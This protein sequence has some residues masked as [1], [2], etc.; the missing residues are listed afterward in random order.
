MDSGKWANPVRVGNVAM[1][2]HC[3]LVAVEH[4]YISAMIDYTDHVGLAAIRGL[5]EL[6][7][8]LLNAMNDEQRQHYG[9]VLAEYVGDEAD[10]CR[11]RAVHF[12]GSVV[13]KGL[14]EDTDDVPY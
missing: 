12:G 5:S 11:Y 13:D 8:R 4:A 9:E 1:C 10:R 7:W 2:P 6:H 14:A 3:L